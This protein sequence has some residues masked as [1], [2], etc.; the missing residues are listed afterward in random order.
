MPSKTT[1]IFIT[2]I[3]TEIGKTLTSAVV[4]KALDADYYKPLQAGELAFTDADTVA[5][6]QGANHVNHG[7]GIGLLEPM[8]PHAAA[9]LEN[10]EVRAK[11]IPSPVTSNLLV[12]E[13]AGGLLVPIN[14]SETIADLIQNDD[15]VILVSKHYLGSINHT[16]LSLEY[17]KNRGHKVGV[18]FIGDQHPST[19]SIIA[20]KT[21]ARILGRMDWAQEVNEEFVSA[22]AQK[23]NVLFCGKLR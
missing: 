6:F 1:R 21:D 10:R 15:F 2:G 13:G 14:T 4:C 9:E 17:L 19:E 5:Q 22:Q 20:K 8:S 7:V 12:V 16:L 11:D 23:L 18:L 3:S